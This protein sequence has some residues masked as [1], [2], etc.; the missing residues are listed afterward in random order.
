VVAQSATYTTG[1]R[2][3]PTVG[4]RVEAVDTYTTGGKTVSSV[5]GLLVRTGG[6]AVYQA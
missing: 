4:G 3:S 1:P 6:G 5:T 2:E